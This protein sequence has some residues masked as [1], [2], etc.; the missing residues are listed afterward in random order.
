VGLTTE[1]IRVPGEGADVPVYLARP[2]DARR[3]PMVLVLHQIYGPNEYTRDLCRRLAHAGYLAVLP[4]LY[5]RHG[6]VEGLSREEIAGGIATKV[7]DA[8]VLADLDRIV[9]W[10][11]NEKGGDSDHLA[12][13]G[14]AWGAQFV[15]LYAAHSPRV[16]AAVSWYGRLVR[17]ASPARPKPW[18][19]VVKELKA[20]VLGIYAGTDPYVLPATLD[21]MREALQE[22]PVATQIAFYPDAKHGFHADYQ[23]HYREADAQDAWARQ[24]AWLARHG[25]AP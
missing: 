19:E 7:E 24:A 14:F 11:A 4:D 23:P 3:A 25:V 21:A 10:A 16:K 12:V 5:F 18:R 6:S 22:A 15:W 8:V 1:A 9:A 17:D 20:P 13:T 2:D